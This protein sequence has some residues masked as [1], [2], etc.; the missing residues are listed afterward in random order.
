MKKYSASNVA[1]IENSKTLKYLTFSMEHQFFLLF[2]T[3]LV[4][5]TTQDIKK[6]NLI[7]ISQIFSLIN[8]RNEKNIL[9]PIVLI[10]MVEKDLS[11]KFWLKKRYIKQEIFHREEMK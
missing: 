7:K 11:L 5:K 10:N 8:N 3:N 1:S 2:I 6:N 9:C 4:L